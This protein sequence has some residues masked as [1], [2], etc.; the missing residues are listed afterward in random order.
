VRICSD[1][2]DGLCRAGG[3]HGSV[4]IVN[5][6]WFKSQPADVQ[7]AIRAAGR[8]AEQQAF[9]WGVENVKKSNAAWKAN[10]GEI[11][12]LAPAEQAS[13]MQSFVALGARIVEQNPAVKAEFAKL[14]ALV[15]ADKPK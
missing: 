1:S 12:S 8:E 11:I 14:K 15:D 7:E 4:D 10:G 6:S 9:P 3:R 13:M 2:V 5:E